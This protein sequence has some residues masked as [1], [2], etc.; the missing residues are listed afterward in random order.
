M[1]LQIGSVICRAGLAAAGTLLVS[2]ACHAIPLGGFPNDP[3]GDVNADGLVTPADAALVQQYI[4]FPLTLASVP[5][6]KERIR[7][8]G[9]V[10][11][12]D[13]HNT[14]G[15]NVVDTNDTQRHLLL[16]GGIIDPGTAGAYSPVG[17]GVY[18]DVNGDGQ[19]DIVDSVILARSVRGIAHPGYEANVHTRGKGDISPT[20]PF[21]G[22]GDGIINAADVS[23]ITA[24]ANGTEANPPPYVDYWPMHAPNADHPTIVSDT[25]EFTDLNGLTGDMN[26][27][28]FYTTQSPK[29]YNGFTVTEIAGTDGSVVGVFKG[30]DGSVYVL[31]VQYP[32]AFGSR[33]I[34]FQ[35]P[36]KIIDASKTTAGQTFGG[37]VVG[38]SANI[39]DRIVPFTVT[40][41]AN[42]DVTTPAAGF[43]PGFSTWSKTLQVRLDI[44][45]VAYRPGQLE[46][47]QAFFFDFTP[48]V[49]M[50]SRGQTA[51]RGSAAPTPD[52]P[53]CELDSATVRGIK[54]SATKP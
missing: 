46:M 28:I 18:G 34:T 51:M 17:G 45:L 29:E 49:G 20:T 32:L 22:F 48:F 52:K 19:V 44:A 27:K 7:R 5:W 37:N 16:G 11:G 9:D 50:V 33:E 1:S 39:G 25:Y 26:H 53:Y 35:S 14:V 40:V 13:V 15:N 42:D 23:V 12:V 6:V 43:Y 54:Y 3:F 31:Y 47:Q 10:A 24:R 21:I 36:V 38:F 41:L 8:Y 30:V 4:D 2:S